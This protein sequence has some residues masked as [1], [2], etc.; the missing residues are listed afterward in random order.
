[1]SLVVA[2]VRKLTSVWTTVIL[3]LVG[4]ALAGVGGA[5]FVFESEVSGE[6]LGQDAQIAAIIDQIGGVAII[7]LV[8]GL[9]SVTTEFRHQTIGR[10]FQLVPSRTRVVATKMLVG[11]VYGLVFFVLGLL[12]LAGVLL[13][14]G[15]ELEFGQQ[16]QAALWQ[17]PVG[18]ALMTV[19]G[20]A[21]GALL[22]SQVVAVALAL[23]HF[24]IVETLFVQFLPEIGRWL[25]FQA[26]N[27]LFTS[28][29]TTALAGEMAPQVLEPLTGLAVFLGYAV[30][31]A[32]A[33]VTL[34]RTRDV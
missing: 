25:P 1:M 24:F 26:L 19:F 22:R 10:T 23:V 27:A 34:M 29:E 8:V 6:F 3:T 17:G 4:I 31:A 14:S 20:V 28:E 13:L 21:L 33:A 32:A 9:L 18:L 11:A 5:F 16:T 12:P 7:A 30:L 15:S 2:E